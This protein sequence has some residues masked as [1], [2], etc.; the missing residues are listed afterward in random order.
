MKVLKVPVEAYLACDDDF[1]RKISE[2]KGMGGDMERER[3][4]NR[5]AKRVTVMGEAC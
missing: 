3:G 1:Y 2:R 4:S 5:G